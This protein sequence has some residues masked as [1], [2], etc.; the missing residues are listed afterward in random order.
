MKL[1]GTC[2]GKGECRLA[3]RFA[4]LV[5]GPASRVGG[6]CWS[7]GQKSQAASAV[8]SGGVSAV[9]GSSDLDE[10]TLVSCGASGNQLSCSLLS[11]LKSPRLP[12]TCLFW[13]AARWCCPLL[14]RLGAWSSSDWRID[15]STA[16]V[17][18]SPFTQL[19]ARAWRFL[20]SNNRRTSRA[21]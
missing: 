19:S 17:R 11:R 12:T 21:R 16:Q 10:H 2:D 4:R 18:W 1:Q 5:K 13:F 15:S 20:E 9:M 14:K 3:W 6:N 8:G 7:R